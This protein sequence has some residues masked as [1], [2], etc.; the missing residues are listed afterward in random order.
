MA[1]KPYVP[2]SVPMEFVNDFGGSSEEEEAG[3]TQCCQYPR[4]RLRR[5]PRAQSTIIEYVPV[6]L[7][8]QQPAPGLASPRVQRKYPENVRN[9]RKVQD[10]TLYEVIVSNVRRPG[11][12]CSSSSDRGAPP[13]ATPSVPRSPVAGRTRAIVY[14]EDLGATYTY[15]PQPAHVVTRRRK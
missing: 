9:N 1:Q 2:V 15:V 3:T 11:A 14:H 6:Q 13:S 5:R 10:N 8:P 12:G 4:A 7:P